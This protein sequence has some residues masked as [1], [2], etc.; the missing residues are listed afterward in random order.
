M[1]IHLEKGKNFKMKIFISHS[2]ED[3]SKATALMETLKPD[4]HEVWFDIHQLLPGDVLQDVIDAWINKC[5]LVVLLWGPAAQK[6]KGVEAELRAAKSFGKRVIPILLDGAAHDDNPQLSGILGIPGEPF[7]TATLLLRRALLMLSATEA[8]KQ[9]GWFKEIFGHITDLGGYLYYVN[10]YRM[11]H[12]RNEDGAKGE[13]VERLQNQV[14]ENERLR[15]ET[16]PA[17]NKTMEELQGI[18][19]DLEHGNVT[20]EQLQGWKQWCE[21]NMAFHPE[22]MGNLRSFIEKEMERMGKEGAVALA[23][24]Y[25]VVEKAIERLDRSIT[26]KKDEAYENMT[27]KV[28]KFGGFLLGEKTV[29]SIVSGYLN[30]VTMCPVLLKQLNDESKTSEYVAVKEALQMVANYLEQQDH[31]ANLVSPSLT[32]FFDEAYFINNTIQVLLEAKLVPAE[33][34][35]YDAAAVSVVNTYVGFVMDSALKTKLDGLVKQV[36]EMV[37]LKKA[38]I[39]WGQ[40]ALLA[41]GTLAVAGGISALTGNKTIE[42]QPEGSGKSFE[43]KVAEFS[44][45]HGGGLSGYL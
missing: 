29:H 1:E 38:E 34:F 28:K 2:W 23:V 31:K 44:A 32:G 30:Y 9:A 26:Q 41:A 6:S 45:K 19:K 11:G 40:V 36:R 12:N 10:T 35:S 22:M 21:T 39:N 43:D 13:W 24:K 15:Q 3:K 20:M 7:E 5:D 27:N 17:M 42:G 33:K 16:L 4:G 8:D 37:G 14:T 25:E 18:M